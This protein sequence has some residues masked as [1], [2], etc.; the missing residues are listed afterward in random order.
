MFSIYACPVSRDGSW[1]AY[2][3]VS[4]LN[5]LIAITDHRFSA[6]RSELTQSIIHAAVLAKT[7]NALSSEIN[8][9]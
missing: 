9:V 5:S 4:L 6:K 7:S 2:V 1:V 3:Q 8:I